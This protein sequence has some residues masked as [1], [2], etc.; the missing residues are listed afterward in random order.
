MSNKTILE[1]ANKLTYLRKL[2]PDLSSDDLLKLLQVSGADKNAAIWLAQE[3]DFITVDKATNEMM[4]ATPPES[5]QLGESVDSLK[6]TIVYCFQQLAKREAD[7]DEKFLT[8]WLVGIPPQDS[9]TA[10]ASLVDN[11]VLFEYDLTD[12]NPKTGKSVYKFYTLFENSEMQWGKKN[13]RKPTK[14]EGEK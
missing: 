1:N 7:L 11:R 12:E 3:L 10:V 8:D 2:Y 13:F 14:A 9:L 5:W 6:E 4:L